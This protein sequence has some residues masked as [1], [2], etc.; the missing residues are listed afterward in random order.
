MITLDFYKEKGSLVNIYPLNMKREWMDN[1]A[2]KHA[3]RCFPVSSANLV[4]WTFSFP[5]DITFIWDGVSDTF[6]DHI[7]IIK[8]H[9]FINLNRANATISFETNLYL[10]TDNDISIM[11]MP[12]P[13]QFIEGTNCFTT[14]INP[15]ILKAPIPAAWKITLANKEITIPANTPIASII[16]ISLKDLQN[17]S[18]NLYNAQFGQDHYNFLQDYGM[19]SQEKTMID[20]WTN[21]YRDG[22]D[23]K[24]NKL[25]E[26]EVKN[27]KLSFN[28]YTKDSN[29]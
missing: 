14:I 2:E 11:I 8:G 28:D 23:H 21:F 4:G 9:K 22:V 29:G 7:K 5:E 3:Y 17:V 24:G 15:S 26:H 1:T 10:K 6:S 20:K 25:G 13:N 19:A 12:V 27:L 18:V 16:P